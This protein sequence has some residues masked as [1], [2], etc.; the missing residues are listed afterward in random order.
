[1]R[2][3]NGGTTRR[4]AVPADTVLVFRS[5]LGWMAAVL[6]G[7]T[8]R[9]LTFGHPTAKAARAALDPELAGQARAT[10][11]RTPLVRRLQAFASGKP[12]D[13]RDIEVDAGPMTDFQRRVMDACRRIPYGGQTSYAALAA[14]AGSPAPRG[15]WATAWPAIG[16]RW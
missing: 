5:D 7:P 3:F 11:R 10:K 12:D 16:C 6:S 2:H 4:A 1:M 13:F 14:A 15:R 9:Q 8:L